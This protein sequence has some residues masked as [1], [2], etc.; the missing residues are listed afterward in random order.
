MYLK[1]QS[2]KQLH[3]FYFSGNIKQV[4]IMII[5]LNKIMFYFSDKLRRSGPFR[6]W[7]Y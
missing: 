7:R 2:L 5:I 4:I 1:I 6:C 3:L